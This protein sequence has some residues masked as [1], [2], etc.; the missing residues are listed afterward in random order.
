MKFSALFD[1]INSHY[2]YK[3]YRDFFSNL[4]NYDYFNTK[5]KE[6][7]DIIQSVIDEQYNTLLFS[8]KRQF[9]NQYGPCLL[10]KDT[11]KNI[12]EINCET[13]IGA[14]P[15]AGYHPLIYPFS[16]NLEIKKRIDSITSDDLYINLGICNKK[17]DHDKNIESKIFIVLTKKEANKKNILDSIN[18]T[19]INNSPIEYTFNDFYI[20]RKN[21][22]LIENEH[23]T[24]NDFL[25][26]LNQKELTNMYLYGYLTKEYV[27]IQKLSNDISDLEYYTFK[28]NLNVFDLIDNNKKKPNYAFTK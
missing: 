2:L 23:S 1:L 5:L 24:K 17:I 20:N 10:T 21:M 9:E 4:Q 11:H 22:I 12:F 18:I 14:L 28:N 27:E 13:F 7:I 6:S 25:K 15:V 26:N 19:M 8:T 3:D 16:C